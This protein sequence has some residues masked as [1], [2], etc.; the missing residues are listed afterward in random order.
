[1]NRDHQ[2]GRIDHASCSDE[3]RAAMVGHSQ[4]TAV[5]CRCR[6]V[7][8][9]VPLDV[10]LE[11]YSA[12]ARSTLISFCT[13]NDVPATRETLHRWGG[14]YQRVLFI[15]SQSEDGIR[16]QSARYNHVAHG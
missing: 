4:C 13:R 7:T 3:S 10:E 14:A 9:T 15:K 12:S 16:L 2:R 1:M 8:L 11:S 5:R 6:A